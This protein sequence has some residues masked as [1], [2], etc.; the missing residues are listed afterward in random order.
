VTDGGGGA[1]LS[2]TD[3]PSHAARIAV[4]HVANAKRGVVLII[5][6]PAFIGDWRRC[7][8]NALIMLRLK[9]AEDGRLSILLLHGETASL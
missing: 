3:L 8:K 7:M 4:R 2:P 1:A 9:A 6:H 5:D